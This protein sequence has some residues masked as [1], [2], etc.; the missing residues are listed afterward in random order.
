ME[1]VSKITSGNQLKKA[2]HFTAFQGNSTMRIRKM[3][4]TSPGISCSA[5]QVE[6][7]VATAKRRLDRSW[8]AASF[9]QLFLKVASDVQW[10]C[11]E[12]GG[13]F[14]ELLSIKVRGS[15]SVLDQLAGQTFSGRLQVRNIAVLLQLQRQRKTLLA[16]KEVKGVGG[17]YSCALLEQNFSPWGKKRLR[18]F[19][20]QCP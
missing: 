11:V 5:H 6:G 12:V 20:L 10:R 8:P 19:F 4:E 16:G 1:D 9:P 2:Q 7:F 17:L 15:V 14:K 3:G 13:M 18:L